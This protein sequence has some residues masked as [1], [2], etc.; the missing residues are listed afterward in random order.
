MCTATHINEMNN[1]EL[2]AFASN[3]DDIETGYAGERID[4]LKKEVQ[5]ELNLREADLAQ[6]LYWS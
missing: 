2:V 1:V 5:H 4:L 3:L 6:D